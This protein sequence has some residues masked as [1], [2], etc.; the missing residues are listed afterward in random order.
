MLGDWKT[1][2][3]PCI[4]EGAEVTFNSQSIYVIPVQGKKDAFIFMADRWN[5]ENA[6]DDRYVWLPINFEDSGLKIRWTEE[7]NVNVFNNK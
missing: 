4:G 3:N 2:G 6:I 7:W 5:P 1:I